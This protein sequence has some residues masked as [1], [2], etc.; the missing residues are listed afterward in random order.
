[1]L[2][3]CLYLTVSKGINQTGKTKSYVNTAKV[4]STGPEVW[5]GKHDR[6]VLGIGVY[7]DISIGTHCRPSDISA[8]S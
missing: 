5:H 6:P 2:A 8:A 1:M 4:M 7:R 3:I